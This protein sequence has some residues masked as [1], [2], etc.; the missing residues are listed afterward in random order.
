MLLLKIVSKTAFTW[1]EF[2]TSKLPLALSA[3]KLQQTLTEEQ[4]REL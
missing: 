1:A 3:P 4:R 2:T